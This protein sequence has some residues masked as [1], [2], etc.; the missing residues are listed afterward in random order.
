[1]SDD[2]RSDLS[3]REDSATPGPDRPLDASADEPPATVGHAADDPEVS[4]DTPARRRRRRGLTAEDT[5]VAAWSPERARR[6]RYLVLVLVI[7]GPVLGTTFALLLV[8]GEPADVLTADEPDRDNPTDLQVS[9]T[10][11]TIDAA[12]GELSVRLVLSAFPDSRLLE[13]SV[14]TEDLRVAVNDEAGGQGVNELVAGEPLGAI[15]LT[16]L[17]EGSRATRYPVDRYESRL[18][19]A[20]R[21]ADGDPVPVSLS[22]RSSDPQFS[23]DVIEDAS[24]DEAVVIRL[25]LQR[26]WTV[27]GWAGF[28][29]VICWLI[30]IS[31][32]SLGW[33]TIVKG[34]ASPVWSWGFLI[35]VLFALPPLRSALP[36]NPQGGSLVDFAAFYWAVG[37]VAFTLVAMIG[38]WNLRVRRAPSNPD[39]PRP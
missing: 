18:V 30:A 5:L 20:V 7:L 15:S 33:T 10:I 16:T 3:R 27:V 21:D 28:F 36:G 8:P 39:A 19:L 34:L 29:V 14:L 38:S 25:S 31:A 2:S 4:N 6:L 1:M 23:V 13:D 24:T 26:R 11:R 22:L 9:G 12:T 37:I 17:L 32:L 35:G